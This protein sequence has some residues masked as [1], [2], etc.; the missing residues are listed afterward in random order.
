MEAAIRNKLCEIEQAE[1]VRILFAVESGSRAW[2]FASPDSDY[3]VRF[4][5]VRGPEFYLKLAPQRDVIEWQLDEILDISGW[6]LQ[7]ALRLLHDSNPTL[8]EWLSSRLVYRSTQESDR[9]AAAAKEY[10]RCKAAAFHYLSMAKSNYHDFFNDRGEVRL[11]KYFYV[12]RALLAARWVVT[13]GEQPPILFAELTDA[14]LPPVQQAAVRKLLAAKMA[15]PELGAGARIAALDEFIDRAF[16]ELPSQA[17]ALPVGRNPG[18]AT[19]DKI[20][21][22]CIRAAGNI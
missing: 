12:L 10:F 3:D 4:I 8:H 22:D 5:Y 17:E 11:K 19:L 21:L 18:W 14:L 13:R 6:D 1:N 20:F 7:K 9:L 2:G 16:A 15:T